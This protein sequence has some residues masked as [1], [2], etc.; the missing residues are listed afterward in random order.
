M[1]WVL[2][3][4]A[5]CA[6]SLFILALYPA[7]SSGIG[8]LA[9]QSHLLPPA[10]H[11]G[12]RNTTLQ[13][14]TQRLDH[15]SC[16]KSLH[17]FQDH[18]PTVPFNHAAAAE[19]LCLSD[20]PTLASCHSYGDDRTFRQR[21]FLN[22]DHWHG[23][24]APILFYCGNEANVELYVNAT[25]LMWERASELGAL[26][27]WAEHRYYGASLP[28]PEASSWETNSSLL[29]W[30]TM[31]QALAD[32]AEIIYTIKRSLDAPGSAVVGNE[33]K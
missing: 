10:R 11:P 24:G 13:W 16:A 28:F 1:A 12:V 19:L 29:R 33:R 22:A 18:S 31:E 15:F 17:D 26:L 6:R 27:V 20:T 5:S 9:H 25:G 23:P 14:H 8:F 3:K 21:V 30:L 4:R 32:Y 7:P 2:P